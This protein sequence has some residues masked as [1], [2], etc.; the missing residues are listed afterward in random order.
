M[1]SDFLVTAL[2]N[3]AS[4]LVLLGVCRPYLVWLAIRSL[5]TLP[6]LGSHYT[7]PK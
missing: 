1:T 7:Q 2:A 4:V 6:C 5:R 3:A